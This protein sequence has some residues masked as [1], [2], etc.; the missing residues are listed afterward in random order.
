MAVGY[1][2]SR[3]EFAEAFDLKYTGEDNKEHRPIML[4]RAILGS[5]ER[6]I[7]VYIEH[8]GGTF[9]TLAMPSASKY[10]E[11]NRPSEPIL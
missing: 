10:L 7:G 11:C 6:F 5:L 3:P 2:A 9:A 8:T 4:H 1:F